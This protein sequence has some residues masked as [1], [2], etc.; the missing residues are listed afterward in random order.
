MDTLVVISID[1][2]YF[3]KCN[4]LR[5]HS[6]I[7]LKVCLE[8]SN[9]CLCHIQLVG[10]NVSYSSEHICVQISTRTYALLANVYEYYLRWTFLW[11]HVN[12]WFKIILKVIVSGTYLFA[13]CNSI[14]AIALFIVV[15]VL[16][17]LYKINDADHKNEPRMNLKYRTGSLE[18]SF[19]NS[20]GCPL[21]ALGSRIKVRRTLIIINRKFENINTMS[22]STIVFLSSSFLGLWDEFSDYIKNHLH[23]IRT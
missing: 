14:N 23:T 11:R 6:H 12:S 4:V 20:G 10:P 15:N 2:I 22:I 1:L 18:F 21:I 9:L 17:K 7:W 3:Q 13:R 16:D 5:L 8:L 19:F